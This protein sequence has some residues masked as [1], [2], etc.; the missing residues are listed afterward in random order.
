MQPFS[1]MMMRENA[2]QNGTKLL[3]ALVTV[4]HRPTDCVSTSSRWRV[5]HGTSVSDMNAPTLLV[6]RAVV[7]PAQGDQIVELGWT[8]VRPVDDVVPVGPQMYVEAT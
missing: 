5:N 2:R 8:A 4:G 6:H 7:R 1:P 3:P